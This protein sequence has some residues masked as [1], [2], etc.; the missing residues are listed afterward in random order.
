MA[1]NNTSSGNGKN[2]KQHYRSA[3]GRAFVGANLYLK[4]GFSLELT[5]VL[6]GSCVPYIAA[7]AK[8]LQCQDAE[9]IAATVRGEKPLLSTA[10]AICSRAALIDSYRAAS[11][12]DLIA[13]G[14]TIGPG[15][16]F[17]RAVMAAL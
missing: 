6:S 10:R 4:G 7:A 12:D 8:I 9:L 11:E 5:A 3:V 1:G 13:F 15:D 17:D 14:R 16:V 2:G